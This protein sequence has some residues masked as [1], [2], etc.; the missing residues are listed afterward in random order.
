MAIKNDIAK[1]T[2]IIDGKQGINELGNLERKFF[3]LRAEMKGMKRSSDDYIAA[4]KRLKTL[5]KD[6][7][8]HRQ[9]LGMAGMTLGQL[10]RWQKQLYREIKN[11]TTKGTADYARLEKQYKE[12]TAEVRKQNAELRGAGASSKSLTKSLMAMGGAYFGIQQL[13]GAVRNLYN[14]VA[15]FDQENANLAA[16]MGDT[17][18]EIREMTKDA[19]RLGSSTAYTSTQVTELQTEL[20]KLGF[21]RREIL[22]LS[23]PILDLAAATG[24]DLA[25][26]ANIAG[27]TL[28]GF[29]KDS[30]ETDNVVNVMAKSF[31]KSA[32]DM[33]KWSVSMSAVAPVANSAGYSIERTTAYLGVLINRGLD[34]STAGTSLRNLFLKLSE[35]GLTFEEAMNKINSASDRNAVAL[36]L[37]GTRGA[38]T[39][40][41]L[42]ST[43]DE[44]ANLEKELTGLEGTVDAMADTQLDSITGDVTKLSSAW[45]GFVLSVENG[46]GVIGGALRGVVQGITEVVNAASYLTNNQETSMVERV[47]G[48]APEDGEERIKF[49]EEQ[50]K[51]AEIAVQGLEKLQQSDRDDDGFFSFLNGK[52]IKKTQ[53]QID[54]FLELQKSLKDELQMIE[55]EK[56]A[57]AKRAKE[58]DEEVERAKL[59]MKEEALEET[60]EVIGAANDREIALLRNKYLSQELTEQEYQ[61]KLK[62]LKLANM[63]QEKEALIESG[64][65]TAEIQ[66]Q[67]NEL[68]FQIAS[69]NL[70]REKQQKLDYNTWLKAFNQTVLDEI[71]ADIDAELALEAHR[72]ERLIELQK[73]SNARK[74]AAE[75]EYQAAKANA[76]QVGVGILADV[77]GQ[78][79][80][81]GQAMFAFE[82]AVAIASVLSNTAQAVARIQAS[83]A[84]ANAQAI[85]ASPLTAGQPWVAINTAIGAKQ[86]ATAKIA[87]GISIAEIAGTF[88]QGISKNKKDKKQGFYHGGDTGTANA[89]YSDAY[90]SVSM[91]GPGFNLHGREIVIPSYERDDP[92]ALNTEAYFASKNPNFKS[93]INPATVPALGMTP[94]QAETLIQKMDEMIATYKQQEKLKESYVLF[95]KIE[96][97]QMEK[98]MAEG[99]GL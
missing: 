45:D 51:M 53:A 80:A 65:E 93:N 95:S 16:V 50:L 83:I 26:A 57:A 20:A 89:G 79:T 48:A 56:L 17:R 12:V 22:N 96:A 9:K 28:R 68:L 35:H 74:I 38:T 71:Q 15:E 87:G 69:E 82:K 64:Q 63:L 46:E 88:I 25:E 1:T 73:D 99:A 43:A 78:Q 8:T 85:A 92:M 54:R 94:E 59:K 19:V 29:N 86:T 81:I 5:E 31:T 10:T 14:N 13:I 3:D 18:K 4:Q 40:T 62:E 49:F 76:L 66:K 72:E 27:S 67:I 60:L 58:A 70:E 21:S 44:V 42:A 97:K 23:E 90:G 77:F 30:K 98:R 37:F 24:T 39:A 34:A 84:M 75:E 61:N 41:I 36:E 52:R 11:T 2:V 33:E 6:I 7:D 55:D 47:F 32:L 91:A